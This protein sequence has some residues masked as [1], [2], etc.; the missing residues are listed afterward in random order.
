MGQA[1]PG[2]IS[3]TYSPDFLLERLLYRDALMLVVNKPP[4]IPVHK[5]MGG[6]ETLEHY[7]DALRFGLPQLPALAH[8]LD[9]ETSGCLVLGRQK[10]A[11]QT[12]G[13][14]FSDNKINKTYWALVEGTPATDEG[15]INLPLAKQSESKKRWWMK[16]ADN[17]GTDS[18]Q[19]AIT[20]YKILGKH[21]N[22]SW[23][24]LTP[25]TGRTHQL[26]VHCAASGYPI[27]GDRIYGNNKEAPQGSLMLHARSIEVPL[28]AKKPPIMV[29]AP[30][31]DHM[32]DLLEK[33]GWNPASDVKI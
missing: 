15:T 16:V 11:L 23:L 31:P 6:G 25:E 22:I 7:F 3:F 24:E 10:H 20:H 17:T 30:L 8:R 12:L 33:C 4:G 13:K 1:M 32:K 2:P 29:V 27:L 14:L 19:T 18:G 28:Y 21:D 5:G 26:R 9:R